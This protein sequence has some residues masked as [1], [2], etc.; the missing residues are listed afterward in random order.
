MRYFCSCCVYRRIVDWVCVWAVQILNRNRSAYKYYYITV[1][2]KMACIFVPVLAHWT[3]FLHH[4]HRRRKEVLFGGADNDSSRARIFGP[5]PLNWSLKVT[6]GSRWFYCCLEERNDGKCAQWSIFE[7][8]LGS[9]WLYLGVSVMKRDRS[10]W[11]VTS[12]GL[13]FGGGA[14]VFSEMYYCLLLFTFVKVDGD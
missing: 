11:F 13:D 12:L 9:F 10:S 1:R 4:V 3:A 14:L 7:A 2:A 5:R 6:R 8:I